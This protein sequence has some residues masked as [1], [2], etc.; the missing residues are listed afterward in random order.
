[1]TEDGRWETDGAVFPDLPRQDYT[2]HD[3]QASDQ[4]I[5][6]QATRRSG[7]RG[8]GTARAMTFSIAIFLNPNN[9]P[10]PYNLIP[11]ILFIG[12]AFFA[13][14]YRYGS[15]KDPERKQ[16]LDGYVVSLSLLMAVYFVNFFIAGYIIAWSVMLCYRGIGR[17]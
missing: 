7:S 11:Y 14:R 17:L 5:G 2:L 12:V 6:N 16:P 13:I 10:D 8:A 1:M 4:V 9:W 15:V 3:G